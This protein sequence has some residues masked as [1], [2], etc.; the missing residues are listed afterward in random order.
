[1][2]PLVIPHTPPGG[3]GVCP[4][5]Y[6]TTPPPHRTPL[7]ARSRDAPQPRTGLWAQ[8]SSRGAR[9]PGNTREY[10]GT[11]G[12]TRNTG[13]YTGIHGNTREYREYGPTGLIRIRPYG[14]YQDTALT[15]LIILVRPVG[16]LALLLEARRADFGQKSRLLLAESR[17]LSGQSR[18]L[19]ARKEPAF[20]RKRSRLSA[21]KRRCFR[22]L[23][24]EKEAGF[25]PK[26]PAS[27][28]KSRLFP[29][30]LPP[31]LARKQ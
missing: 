8:P 1:M 21:R 10:P 24:A 18:L 4:G 27:L 15:G 20:G 23:L 2:Y 28:A 22:E 31:A 17:L 19:L 30:R 11:P 9:R 3:Y 25:W 16:P 5:R 12:N 6:T 7:Y 26:E 14:P 29:R 13:E